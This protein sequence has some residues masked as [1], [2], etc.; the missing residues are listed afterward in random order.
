MTI[1]S[2]TFKDKE[3]IEEMLSIF[4]LDDNGNEIDK[5]TFYNK[6]EE[7]EIQPILRESIQKLPE[8]LDKIYC[9]GKSNSQ[10]N[11]LTEEVIIQ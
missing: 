10:I 6:K 11:F 1:K 3:S 8:L 9:S 2:V 7:N 5:Y 4:I